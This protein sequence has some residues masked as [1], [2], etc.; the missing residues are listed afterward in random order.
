MKVLELPMILREKS[1]NG[2][3]VHKSLSKNA[4]VVTLFGGRWRMSDP[5][6]IERRTGCM[7]MELYDGDLSMR[8]F[9]NIVIVRV[10]IAP[11]VKELEDLGTVFGGV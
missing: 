6:L 10:V 8:S 4:H 9:S 11:L 7:C 1:E 2:S 5:S 3:S